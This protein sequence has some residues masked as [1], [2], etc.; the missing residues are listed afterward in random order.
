MKIYKIDEKGK[1][2]CGGHNA[3]NGFSWMDGCVKPELPIPAGSIVL[4]KGKWYKVEENVG[5][6]PGCS[7]CDVS[8]DNCFKD[9]GLACHAKTN[10]GFEQFKLLPDLETTEDKLEEGDYCQWRGNLYTVKASEKCSESCNGCEITN[11]CALNKKNFYCTGIMGKGKNLK[12]ICKA[13]EGHPSVCDD[14]YMP[15]LVGVKLV[16]GEA[17]FYFNGKEYE[18]KEEKRFFDEEMLK[19][20][21]DYKIDFKGSVDHALAVTS[22]NRVTIW[23]Y[24]Y[25][26][27]ADRY[28]KALA[29][30]EEEFA[31]RKKPLTLEEAKKMLSILRVISI[32]KAEK[33][34]CESCS[35]SDPG[36]LYFIK[37][38]D[39]SSVWV[40][41]DCVDKWRE[42]Q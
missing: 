25:R 31:R 35:S 36:C 18:M 29:E 39:A 17:K 20:I 32:G 19:Q 2:D 4:I 21:D 22:K 11:D 33:G 10:K 40:C 12:L 24:K 38:K 15:N 7:G 6:L 23:I 13:E 16:G 27:G 28:N 30:L 37:I 41:Q 9:N 26:I 34:F 3:L 5:R 1:V 14:V 8:I 42:Q